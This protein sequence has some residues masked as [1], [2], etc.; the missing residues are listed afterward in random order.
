VNI[1]DENIPAAQRQRLET[2]HIRI[3]Q[4]GFNVGRRGMQDDEIIAF[5]QHLRRPTFFSRDRDFFERQLAHRKYGLV[6][7][8]VERD[9]VALFVRRVLKHSAFNTQVKRLGI[10]LRVSSAGVAV[11]RPG[12]SNETQM[13]WE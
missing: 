8:A 13:A 3:R 5:L 9:E 7:L 4:I 12:L 10:I 2:W 1:L 11:L 6:Y